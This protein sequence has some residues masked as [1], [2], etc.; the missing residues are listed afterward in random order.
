M[1]GTEIGGPEG[2][3]AGVPVVSGERGTGNVTVQQVTTV[4]GR[5]APGLPADTPVWGS[6]KDRPQT[7][8][9]VCG[10][11]GHTCPPSDGMSDVLRMSV[12]TWSVDACPGSGRHGRWAMVGTCRCGGMP[13]GF[14]SVVGGSTGS[15]GTQRSGTGTGGGNPDGLRWNGQVNRSMARSTPLSL[16]RR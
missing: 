12:R 3:F 10:L 1:E 16:I 13:A 4:A 5:L 8:S 11:P 14:P 6:R 7:P 9:T 15:H 2:L